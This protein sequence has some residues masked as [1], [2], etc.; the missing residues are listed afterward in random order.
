MTGDADTRKEGQREGNRRL[1]VPRRFTVCPPLRSRGSERGKAA[2]S[3]AG[4]TAS[5]CHAGPPFRQYESPDIP[6]IGY[7]GEDRRTKCARSMEGGTA[8]F[9]T[10][11]PATKLPGGRFYFAP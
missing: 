5:P 4:C 9:H 8:G 7:E 10:L 2:A 3:A 11:V 6:V 1:K